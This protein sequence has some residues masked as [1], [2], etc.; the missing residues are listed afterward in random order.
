MV[1]RCKIYPIA[2]A[3]TVMR[4]NTNAKINV[5]IVTYYIN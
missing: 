3:A 1:L 2:I 4:K 5:L